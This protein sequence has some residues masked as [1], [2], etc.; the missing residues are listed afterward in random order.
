MNDEESIFPF[1]DLEED[2]EDEEE[3][4]EELCEYAYDFQNNCLLKNE[5]GQ[6]YY[7]YQDEALKVWIHKALMTPR[8]H[9][10]AYTED[11]GS[12]H[13]TLIGQTIDY[14]IACQEL[15][16]FIIEALMYNDYVRE[17]SNFDFT[18]NEDN[19]IVKFTVTS[20]YGEFDIEEIF[21]GGIAYG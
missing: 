21:D 13:E 4:L 19:V 10:L 2:E 11:F 8:Y 6:N 5:S 12:E 16:R 1:I 3:E 20:V 7:V 17:L 18:M 14:D 9:H 15:K